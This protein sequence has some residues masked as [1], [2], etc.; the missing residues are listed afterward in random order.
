MELMQTFPLTTSPSYLQVTL[1][2]CFQS[3]STVT[4]LL[5][6]VLLGSELARGGD[7]ADVHDR[8]GLTPHSMRVD[9]P[10]RE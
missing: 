1:D 4:V 6:L 8:G 9:H 10:P 5:P 3:S 2:R 7:Q